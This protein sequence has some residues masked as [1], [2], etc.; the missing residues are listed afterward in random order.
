[1]QTALGAKAGSLFACHGATSDES[2]H[3]PATE[4]GEVH[5]D[6]PIPPSLIVGSKETLLVPESKKSRDFSWQG[7]YQKRDGSHWQGRGANLVN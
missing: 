5:N 4:P 2:Y 7:R 1:M 3:A 6:T